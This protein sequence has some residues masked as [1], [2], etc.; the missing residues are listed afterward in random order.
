MLSEL[1]LPHD[2]SKQLVERGFDE[3]CFSFY[4]KDGKLA[5][6]HSNDFIAKDYTQKYLES[7]SQS[8][9]LAPTYQQVCEWFR[10]QKHIH[11]QP[12]W[13]WVGENMSP[14][15][16]SRI[17]FLNTGKHTKVFEHSIDYNTA[18]LNGIIEALKSI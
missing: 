13:A 15:Y 9:C 18:L 6:Y 3:P 10:S 5:H 12:E 16:F 1:F 4:W 17:I 2:V 11:I 7:N 14:T 8:D